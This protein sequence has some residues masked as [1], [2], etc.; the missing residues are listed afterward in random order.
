MKHI[1]KCRVCNKDIKVYL[2]EIKTKHRVTCSKECKLKWMSIREHPTKYKIG[3]KKTNG[4]IKGDKHS[5]ETKIKISKKCI[6]KVP[7]NK[8]KHIKTNDA[9]SIWRK[10]REGAPWNK[11]LIGVQALENHP[12]WQGGKSFEPYSKEFSSALKE[13]IRF[14]GNYRCF[15]CGCTQL[16][17]GMALDVHHIDYNKKN[18]SIQNLIALCVSCHRKTNWNREYWLKYFNEKLVRRE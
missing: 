2:C 1:I 10:I 7:P 18:S 17:N 5:D 11:G 3:R 4:F 12:N 14:L 15:I 6:G 8:G 9:L 16:E 13:R